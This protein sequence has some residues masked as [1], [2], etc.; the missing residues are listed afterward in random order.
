[1]ENLA[2]SPSHSPFDSDEQ[3]SISFPSFGEHTLMHDEEFSHLS[4]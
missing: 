1:M 2:A 4:L 3:V